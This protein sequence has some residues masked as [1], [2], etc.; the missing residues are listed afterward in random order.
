M[1]TGITV[2]TNMFSPRH[3]R[4]TKSKNVPSKIQNKIIR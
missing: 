4:G 2:S 1:N 3:Y